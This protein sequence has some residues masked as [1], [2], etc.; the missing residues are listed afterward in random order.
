MK[1]KGCVSA[2]VLIVLLPFQVFAQ[3]SLTPPGTPAETM[4]TLEQ[5]EPRIDV[6]TVV[7][8]S[9]YHHVISQPG[10][11]Y[12]SENVGVTKANGI[13]IESANVTLDLNGF[14]IS[15]SQ[16]SDNLT[17]AAA[18]AGFGMLLRDS[19]FKG[20]TSYEQ[21]LAMARKSTGEDRFGYR[22]DFI[23]LVETARL[24]SD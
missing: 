8:N 22:K 21:V 10:S 3:G 2:A 9:S 19:E 13:M 17:F 16:A 20:K 18:V 7:G 23:R 5:V 14:N 6:A 15:P 4:K 11:Y 24:L 12:L 1:V